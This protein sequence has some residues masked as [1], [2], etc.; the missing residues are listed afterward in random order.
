VILI[1]KIIRKP[2]VSFLGHID[3]GKTTLLDK[4]RGTSVQLK[5]AG[6]I[7]QHIGATEIPISMVER[8]AGD[9]AK[10]FK[11][12]IKIPGLLI[13]DTPGHAAFVSMRKLGGTLADLAVLV[14]DINEGVMAQ[15]KESLEILINTKTPFVI[16]ANK[17]D[18]IPGWRSY[19]E[20][21]FVQSF[22]KQTEEVKNLFYERLYMLIGDLGYFD[23]QADLFTEIKDF[24]E[25][26]P[27]V[28]VSAKTGE[29]LA[30]LLLIVSGVAQR[31]LGDKLYISKDAPGK[32]TIIEIKEVKGA[33][34]TFD[35]IL[36]D[37][38]L[39]VGDE[40]AF[41]TLD[42]PRTSQIKAIYKPKPK[43]E[44]RDSIA[45]FE[46]INEVYAAAGIKIL[47]REPEKALT[48]SPIIAINKDNKEEVINELKRQLKEVIFSSEDCGVVVK[49]D[50]FGTLQGILY[51]L[52][53]SNIPV[54][55]AGIGPVCKEDIIMAEVS[56]KM[57]EKYG[58]V[59]A[60]NVQ[61][62][63]EARD[64][65]NL[66]G[67]RLFYDTVIYN[68]IDQVKDYLKNIEEEKVKKLL[69]EVTLPCRFRIVE[70]C[71][72]RKSKPAIVGVK[73]LKGTIRPGATVI[74]E[75]GKEI[76]PIKELQSK[77][78]RVSEAIAGQ[79]VAVS[80]ENATVGRNLKLDVEYYTK[81]TKKDIEIL[82]TELKDYLRSD[83]L[84]VLEEYKNKFF[85]G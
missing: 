39:K 30:E 48:D 54:K 64:Y 46:P 21:P 55:S 3:H 71:I 11:F 23:I 33:G 9:L 81:L 45:A 78:E 61:V 69:S 14:I 13:I 66:R 24:K 26:V 47:V 28:P 2:I 82:E 42:G 67:I 75:D 43:R 36:Y 56:K 83:E 40:V 25:T 1:S 4:I 16:A 57:D 77:G 10:Q 38:G 29:G 18:M 35:V 74:R 62:P 27:I 79:E 5:E 65:A 49:A 76:G 53:L 60:F 6:G 80:I 19:P 68:L 73:V 85:K 15:T 41:L 59:L 72:F 52:R 7:T 37:G 51:E 58:I 31:F 17:I 70:N 20:Q 22:S 8:I 12:D 84:E 50:T 34:E 44:T 63:Q 32:G